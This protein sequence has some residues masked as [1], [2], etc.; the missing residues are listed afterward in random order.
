M[1]N[2]WWIVFEES[3]WLCFERALTLMISSVGIVDGYSLHHR[4]RSRQIFGGAKYF[5]PNFPKR[6]RNVSRATLGASISS[7]LGWPPKK[8]LRV[9]IFIHIFR[10]LF[11]QNF[12]YFANILIDLAQVFTDFARIFDK[13]KLFG[14]ALA[15]P[16]YNWSSRHMEFE[17]KLV[18]S[19]LTCFVVTVDLS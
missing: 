16:L 8:G 12:R 4:C 9:A 11:A 10:Q 15:P 7:F 2:F 14:G 19:A 6:A 3:V 18:S 13:S 1:I 17:L 5:C